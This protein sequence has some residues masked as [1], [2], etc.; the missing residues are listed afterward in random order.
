MWN[1]GKIWIRFFTAEPIKIKL[2]GQAKIDKLIDQSVK[3]T[4]IAGMLKRLLCR[5]SSTRITF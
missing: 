4:S 5:D 3:D 1:I 2:M